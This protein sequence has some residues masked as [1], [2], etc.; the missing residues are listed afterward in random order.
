MSNVHDFLKKISDTKRHVEEAAHQV[1]K[2][3][4]SVCI[5]N[6]NK[7]RYIEACL[8]SVGNQTYKSIE[9]ILIDDSSSDKSWGII[10]KFKR[11]NPHLK[12]I[13]LQL[14]FRR[15]TAWVQNIAYYLAR[16]EYLMNMDS[17][18]MIAPEKIEKQVRAMETYGWDVCGTNFKIF[19]TD[20]SRPLTHDGGHWL[21]YD[22]EEI[23]DSYLFRRIH[24]V[25]FGSLMYKARVIEVIAGMTKEF[26]GT[27]D[28]EIVYR[29]ASKGFTIGNIKDALYYY[30]SNDTQR[31]KLFHGSSV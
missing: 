13:T 21:K 31:S 10:Q 19:K 17:D 14:P 27:E 7:E 4:V 5:P 26:I 30:R 28:Y 25:C 20:P 18:D 9:I 1:N 22:T 15:G 23:E 8:K 11:E 12:I 16:G 24:C 2:G 3:L 29:I 6:F